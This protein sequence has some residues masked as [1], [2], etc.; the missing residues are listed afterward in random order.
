MFAM[1]SGCK[2]SAQKIRALLDARD[3]SQSEL[4]RRLGWERMR[5]N[6]RLNGGARIDLTELSEIAR[7]LGVDAAELLPDEAVVG[8]R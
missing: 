1:P 4:A 5:V 7:A 6:R 2:T 3:I 8:A